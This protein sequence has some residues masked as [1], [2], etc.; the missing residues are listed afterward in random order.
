MK[1]YNQMRKMAQD[2]TPY[3]GACYTLF[4]EDGA[5]V[6][7]V[8]YVCHGGLAARYR[9]KVK[10]IVENT[11]I[12]ASGNSVYGETYLREQFAI[13]WWDTLLNHSPLR[14][15]TDHRSGKNA[16][17]TGVLIHTD[18]GSARE[19]RAF[20]MMLRLPKERA[21]AYE[22]WE[23][24]KKHTNCPYKRM[25]AQMFFHKSD[26][27]IVSYWLSEH[28]PFMPEITKEVWKKLFLKYKRDKSSS[29]FNGGY[30]GD[31]GVKIK[32][33]FTPNM[34]RNRDY[35]REVLRNLPNT[36]KEFIELLDKEVG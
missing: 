20:L 32:E 19:L 36:I 12:L 18:R 10:Y 1:L 34:Y 4:K 27:R 26:S 30:D 14:F 6:S 16:A 9:H 21:F 31:D 5:V 2:T 17:K 13:E 33:L 25:F 22:V 15:F 7:Q 23:E 28:V 24:I 3:N 29:Y 8:S 11:K 35:M